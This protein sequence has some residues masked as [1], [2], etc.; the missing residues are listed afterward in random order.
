MYFR[1]SNFLRDHRCR[2]FPIV[3]QASLVLLCVC[4]SIDKVSNQVASLSHFP[5]TVADQ[6]SLFASDT[7][8]WLDELFPVCST[9]SYFSPAIESG[10][11]EN[12][13]VT[14][15]TL[16]V[17]ESFA[18]C[19]GCFCRWCKWIAFLRPGFFAHGSLRKT[20]HMY[21]CRGPQSVDQSYS[22]TK[23]RPAVLLSWLGCAV[24]SV[25]SGISE[26]EK[27]G[28]PVRMTIG[29]SNCPWL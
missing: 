5:I 17:Q 7:A 13:F 12:K 28:R 11:D 3:R 15:T 21:V 6:A 23:R 20:V 9:I 2:E 19:G 14:N 1:L 16:D 22:T 8:G 26:E 10:A 4:C 24:S 29:A 27:A 25:A 18:F